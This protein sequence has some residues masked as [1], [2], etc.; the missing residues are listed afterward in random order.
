M[1]NA[2]TKNSAKKQNS[3]IYDVRN[4]KTVTF[5]TNIVIRSRSQVFTL[6]FLNALFAHVLKHPFFS[7]FF[8]LVCASI[9]IIGHS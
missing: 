1:I 4:I 8:R 5:R 9:P 6:V 2:Q 7:F 3:L